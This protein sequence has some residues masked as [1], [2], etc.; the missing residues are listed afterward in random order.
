L[1]E[2]CVTVSDLIRQAYVDYADGRQ[3]GP[4]WV[5]IE[6]GPAWIHSDRM[7]DSNR[8]TIEAKAEGTPDQATMKGPMLQ[9]LL[10]DRFKLKI[11]RESREIP[12]YELTLAKGGPKLVRSKEGSCVPLDYS[13]PTPYPQFCG[14]PKRGGTGLQLIGAT[15][16]DLSKVLSAPE[17]SDRPT[18]DKTGITGMFDIQLPAPGELTGRG[19][20]DAGVSRPNDPTPAAADPSFSPFEALRTAVEKLGLTLVRAKGSGERLVIDRVERPSEN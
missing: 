1:I 16:A 9:A 12:I 18:V 6:G 11:R 17:I 7:S 19:A 15:M 10:A 4:S 8:Y 5:P 14:M 3:N 13:L 2:H 20:G